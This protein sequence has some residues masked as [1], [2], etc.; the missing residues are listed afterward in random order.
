[1]IT[2][3]VTALYGALN[4]ILNIFLANRVS[5]LR[6]SEGIGI[7]VGVGPPVLARPPVGIEEDQRACHEPLSRPGPGGS[8]P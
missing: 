3:T 8:T 4:A 5:T 1:M 2:P 7:G 6:R